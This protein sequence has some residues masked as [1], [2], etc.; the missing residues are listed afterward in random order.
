MRLDKPLMKMGGSLVVTMPNEVLEEW[1]L[2][3]GDEVTLEVMD[4]AVRIEPRQPTRTVAI[5]EASF[6]EYSKV[7]KRI[8]ARVTLNPEA[9][10]LHIDLLGEDRESISA[11]LNNLWRNIPFLLNMLGL[12]SV[13]TLSELQTGRRKKKA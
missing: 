11:V 1:N 10:S 9:G 2:G 4:G 3:K 6:E 13:E 5:S 12:G 8:Q 7:M